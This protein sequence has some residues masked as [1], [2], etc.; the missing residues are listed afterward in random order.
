MVAR[1]PLSWPA[2]A[3]VRREQTAPVVAESL[4]QLEHALTERRA[5]GATRFSKREQQFAALD[6]QG[7][8]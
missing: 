2:R 4:R 7:H 6:R 8:P 1:S 3:K 5:R